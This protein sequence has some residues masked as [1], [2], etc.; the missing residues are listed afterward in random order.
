[1]NRPI[2]AAGVAAL[3]VLTGCSASPVGGANPVPKP[4]ATDDVQAE[5]PAE[6]TTEPS[7]PPAEP[8]P[9]TSEEE[10]SP[11]ADPGTGVGPG[12]DDLATC[13]LGT[14]SADMDELGSVMALDFADLGDLAAV[15]ASGA[16]LSTYDGDRVTWTYQDV[17]FKF[18]FGGELD[19]V[20]RMT[21]DG[22]EDAHY[23]VEGQ[24]VV[25]DDWRSIDAEIGVILVMAGEEIDLME[26]VDPDDYVADTPERRLSATCDERH[27]DQQVLTIGGL[28]VP[29]DLPG[30]RLTRQ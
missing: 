12:G 8:S 13:L 23:R 25:V 21:M 19:F 20:V 7:E 9:E 27:L 6:P 16:S 24:E 11:T 29:A 3:L 14:W 22:R 1:M 4:S 26:G 18:T 30:T 10:A 28:P 5:S 15:E 17:V 2:L